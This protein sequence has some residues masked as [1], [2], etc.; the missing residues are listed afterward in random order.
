MSK[1]PDSPATLH[2]LL[3]TGKFQQIALNC[4]Y[5]VLMIMQ[6]C[7]STIEDDSKKMN[8]MSVTPT[9]ESETLAITGFEIKG[10]DLIVSCRTV[11]K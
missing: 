8:L 4:I 1:H 9:S 5:S 11:R 10:E 6:I 2:N 3:S 7:I